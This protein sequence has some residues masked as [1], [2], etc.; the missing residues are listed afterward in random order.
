ML[1]TRQ[2][3]DHLPKDGCLKFSSEIKFFGYGKERK[4]I[5]G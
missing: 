5:G 1:Y 3:R 2:H 4:K